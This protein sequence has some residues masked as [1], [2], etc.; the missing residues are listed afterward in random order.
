[1]HKVV[2]GSSEFT[3]KR[4]ED[5]NFIPLQSMSIKILFF[6]LLTIL[7]FTTPIVLA[8]ND[9]PINISDEELQKIY[10]EFK[11]YLKKKEDWEK[12]K[13]KLESLKNIRRMDSSGGAEELPYADRR[14]LS[15]E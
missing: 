7:I 5:F 9:Q 6:I 10:R 12:I 11:R 14:N 13:E 8:F 15:E 4:L 1:M 2:T 3:V